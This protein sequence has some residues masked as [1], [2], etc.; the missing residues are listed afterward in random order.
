MFV[1]TFCVWVQNLVFYLKARTLTEGSEGTL[2][3]NRRLVW[4]RTGSAADI[5]KGGG[6][7]N[8][9]KCVD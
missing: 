6:I 2:G 3:N 9:R 1:I 5:G 4:L 7:Y 8:N